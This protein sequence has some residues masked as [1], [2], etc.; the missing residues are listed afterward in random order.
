MVDTRVCNGGRWWGAGQ[1]RDGRS[2]STRTLSKGGPDLRN[3]E[4][5]E[6]EQH[7][8]EGIQGHRPL[9]EIDEPQPLARAD[10][11][12]GV[13]HAG[14]LLAVH[15]GKREEAEHADDADDDDGDAVDL[16]P[17]LRPVVPRAIL[18]DLVRLLDSAGE[19]GQQKEALWTYTYSRDARASVNDGVRACVR[20]SATSHAAKRGLGCSEARA[21]VCG[22]RMVSHLEHTERPLV[23]LLVCI[24]EVDDEAI[25]ELERRALRERAH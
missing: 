22:V 10:E 12:I 18:V 11:G 9:H 21:A 16:V 6:A 20:E 25:I 7:K 5:A 15:H 4:R 13:G 8:R 2:G 19:H 24:R 1:R 3:L 14:P 17:V 23:V